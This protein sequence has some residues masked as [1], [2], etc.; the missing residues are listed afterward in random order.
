MYRRLLRHVR[1]YRRLLAGGMLA[2]LAV[3][4]A[5]SAYAFLVGPLLRA[6]L[7]EAPVGVGGVQLQGR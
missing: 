1:P 6:V 7:T 4:A 2:A 5:A 3:A